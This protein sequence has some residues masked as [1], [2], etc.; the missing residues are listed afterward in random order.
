MIFITFSSWR[1]KEMIECCLSCPEPVHS[2]DGRGVALAGP[3][4]FFC[5]C[6]H[7]LK[8]GP[9]L[10]VPCQCGGGGRPRGAPEPGNFCLQFPYPSSCVP[11]APPKDGSVL[12]NLGFLWPL[13]NLPLGQKGLHEK[14]MEGGW[15]INKPVPNSASAECHK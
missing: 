13:G 8:S 7:C 1:P 14:D 6:L 2:T 10:L 4:S 11:P 9:L 15:K 12:G 5:L 3:D